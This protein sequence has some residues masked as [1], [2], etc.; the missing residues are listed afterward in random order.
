MPSKTQSIVDDYRTVRSSVTYSERNQANLN[1]A[2]ADSPIYKG[3][4]TDDLIKEQF[5]ELVQQ[6][7]VPSGFG[8]NGFSRDYTAN[9]APNLEDVDTSLKGIG[10]PYMPNLNSPGEGNGANPNAAQ[11]Y[12]GTR[13]QKA[14]APTLWGAPG[15]SGLVSPVVT[16]EGIEGQARVG[17]PPRGPINP[18]GAARISKSYNDSQIPE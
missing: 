10:T 6:G 5:V 7:T 3:E 13:G 15:S 9:G 8:L 1:S 11:P 16:S 17:S 12:D 4:L 2:F 18:A 14:N